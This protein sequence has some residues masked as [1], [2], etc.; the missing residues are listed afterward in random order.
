M[1]L[2]PYALLLLISVPTARAQTPSRSQLALTILGGAISGHSLWEVERQPVAVPGVTGDYDTLHV[3]RAI[4]SSVVVGAAATY[5][6]SPHVGMHAEISYMGL[7]YDDSCTDLHASASDGGRIQAACDDIASEPGS[8]GAISLFVG[9]TLR[10]AA[11]RGFSPYLRGNIGVVSMPH[12]YVE[13]IGNYLTSV[14]PQPVVVIRDPG[15]RSGA[16]LFGL[17]AGFTEPLGKA[18]GYQVRFELR[19]AITSFELVTGPADPTSLLAPTDIKTYHHLSLT[20]GLDV[21]L[22]KARGRRY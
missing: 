5:F 11:T 16:P 14:G 17:A 21:V 1:R 3:V 9:A 8:G 15:P 22:E 2:A 19:D 12:S 20:I 4:S 6:F 7:P 10:A 13:M 18:G